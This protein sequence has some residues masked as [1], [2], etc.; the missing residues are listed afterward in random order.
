MSLYCRPGGAF[1]HN[2]RALERIHIEWEWCSGQWVL[3]AS[4][5]N[6]LW[7]WQSWYRLAPAHLVLLRDGTYR[8]LIEGSSADADLTAGPEVFIAST[9]VTPWAPRGTYRRL[10]ELTCQANADAEHISSRLC[11]RDGRGR[12]MRRTIGPNL[13]H[14]QAERAA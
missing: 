3:I 4:K 14:L 9:V 1:A 13:Y 11:K 5:D 12:W 2:D 7:G 10:F 6:Q 8:D